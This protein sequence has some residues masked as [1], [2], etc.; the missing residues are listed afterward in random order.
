MIT[1][2]INKTI[3]LKTSDEKNMLYVYAD[4]LESDFEL[5]V[6]PKSIAY[7]EES[8]I[9]KE[10]DKIIL[11][12][13]STPLHMLQIENKNPYELYG[14]DHNSGILFFGS[15]NNID[16]I[17]Q[18]I[19]KEY[20]NGLGNISFADLTHEYT[21]ISGSP[22]VRWDFEDGKSL[23]ISYFDSN[24]HQFS[25][26]SSIKGQDIISYEF[27]AGMDDRLAHE[28]LQPYIARILK[29]IK[30]PLMDIEMD[31]LGDENDYPIDING[32]FIT[33]KHNEL[34]IKLAEHLY[35][36]IIHFNEIDDEDDV[37]KIIA[38]KLIKNNIINNL[39]KPTSDTSEHLTY[40]Y[41]TSNKEY[42][43]S[44][45]EENNLWV[46][47]TSYGSIG[48]KMVEDTQISTSNIQEAQDIYLGLLKDK[49]TKGY[50][51]DKLVQLNHKI[52]I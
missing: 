15:S 18:E 46:V 23:I 44:F 3:P 7:I 8:N 40:I 22:F 45:K 26:V 49:L 39:E 24:Y 36:S 21:H 32:K 16:K 38:K 10:G 6:Q 35:C 43:I 12:K 34:L 29:K 25:N 27:G 42:N 30:M 33:S 13:N 37:N 52:K 20:L 48:K 31:E 11:H 50:D 51:L 17:H 19:E 41:G 2:H 9:Y 47:V 14:S 1:L 5:G 4:I 28:F